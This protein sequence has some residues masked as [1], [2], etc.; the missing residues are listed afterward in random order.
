M[1]ERANSMSVKNILFNYQLNKF[2]N[3]VRADKDFNIVFFNDPEEHK[4]EKLFEIGLNNKIHFIYKL[5]KQN[6]TGKEEVFYI[7]YPKKNLTADAFDSSEVR[8]RILYHMPHNN[9]KQKIINPIEVSQENL[10][11][12]FEEGEYKKTITMR[13]YLPSLHRFFVKLMAALGYESGSDGKCFGITYM[14]MQAWLAGDFQVF[15]E[16]LNLLR[17]KTV[18]AWV[19][20]LKTIE[21]RDENTL[22]E[23][24]RDRFK[25]YIDLR[26]FLDGVALYQDF[27]SS[28][29]MDVHGRSNQNHLHTAKFTLP[30][31]LISQS[32][33]DTF[34]LSSDCYNQIQLNQIFEALRTKLNKA[35]LKQRL[36]FSIDGRNYDINHQIMVH[37]D[38][39]MPETPW[40]LV[41]SCQL[42]EEL[43]DREFIYCNSEKIACL[44]MRAFLPYSQKTFNNDDNRAIPYVRITANTGARLE[45]RPTACTTSL[46][47]NSYLIVTETAKFYYVNEEKKLIELEE[48]KGLE[49]AIKEY[50]ANLNKIKE[51]QSDKDRIKELTKSYRNTEI[52]NLSNDWMQIISDAKAAA[53]AQEYDACK[54][55][56][57]LFTAAGH[58]NVEKVKS[59]LQEGVKA[60]NADNI[61]RTPLWTAVQNGR[62]EVV[63]LLLQ[64]TGVDVNQAD[65]NGRTPIWI[66]VQNGDIAVVSLL[67]Q[68]KS[69]K[70]NQADA[71]GQT[72]L[73]M[74]VDGSH[75]GLV[76]LLLKQ[77]EINLNQDNDRWIL[78]CLAARK[79]HVEIMKMLLQQKE[80]DVNRLDIGRRTPLWIAAAHGHI[81]VVKLLLQQKEVDVNRSDIGERTPLWV[82]VANG[83]IEVVRLL[84]QQ[85]KVDV[86]RA[87]TYNFTPLCVSC[88]YGYVEV[89]ESL[90][91]SANINQSNENA[92]YTPL[93]LAIQ[94]R[95]ANI[96]NLLLQRGAAANVTH[97]MLTYELRLAAENRGCEKEMENLLK[98]KGE[99]EDKVN[100]TSLE[101]AALFGF[102]EI[103]SLLKRH[104]EK[105]KKDQPLSGSTKQHGFLNQKR[106]NQTS[107]NQ[108]GLSSEKPNFF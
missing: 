22:N 92:G 61:G 108:N 13:M 66:A 63:K 34:F 82:A 45:M 64:Q 100:L 17:T 20:E 47:A 12:K 46:T 19:N 18:E 81:E 93:L 40:V 96:V 16:R 94:Y 51:P 48:V 10:K 52:N 71:A 1:L 5:T 69:I 87:D 54:V 4:L 39:E 84:L 105:P 31:A 27:Y 102:Q 83:H 43:L 86:N 25:Q 107:D 104:I 68:Q 58:G 2:E 7:K 67:L 77:K 85:E 35:S 28:L 72:L 98:E 97:S 70:I 15:I 44:I 99:K 36:S 14:S 23:E 59:L 53:A 24:E 11:K 73:S 95:H 75:L 60:N 89:V 103:V 33:F 55:W 38:P 37:Y 41:D 106:K 62:T 3:N 49:D 76:E 57:L 78:T 80:M 8:K 29:G 101:I 65:N 30:D 56:Q 32:G 26:A 21:T 88:Q 50:Q 6:V 90:L 91:S 9:Q 74:A 79:G 42:E